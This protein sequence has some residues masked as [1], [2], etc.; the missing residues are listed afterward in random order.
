MG[1]NFF[2][3]HHKLQED[4][5]ALAI[6]DLPQPGDTVKPTNIYDLVSQE[7]RK[8]DRQLRISYNRGIAQIFGMPKK[9]PVQ[10]WEEIKPGTVVTYDHIP[11]LME[12]IALVRQG[13]R[14]FMIHTLN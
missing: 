8:R 4:L 1:G 9:I 10:Y 3:M 12:G 14:V 13:D 7:N 2:H 6:D 11:L 5:N